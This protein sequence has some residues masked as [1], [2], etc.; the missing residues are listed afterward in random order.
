MQQVQTL[1]SASTRWKPTTSGPTRVLV[2]EDEHDIAA[3]IKHTLERGGDARVDIVSSGDD[4][5]RAVTEAPPH[6][7]ILDLNLPV[8]SG[9]E[10]CRILRSRPASAEVPIIM[11]TARTGELDRVSGARPRRRRL[12][13]QAVQHP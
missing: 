9:F 13:H 10:V 8:L 1:D 12:R 6:L 5:V 7:V 11:L 3:L 4:A 2:V